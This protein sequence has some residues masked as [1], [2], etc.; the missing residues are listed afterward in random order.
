MFNCD[1]VDIFYV[2]ITY[3]ISIFFLS[4]LNPLNDLLNNFTLLML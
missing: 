1:F 4:I 3:E 2:I